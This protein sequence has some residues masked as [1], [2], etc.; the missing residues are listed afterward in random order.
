MNFKLKTKIVRAWFVHFLTCSGLIAG[1]LSITF[2]FQNDQR[3]AFMCLGLALLIDTIDGT[4]A[5]K[6]KVSKYVKNIDGKMLDSVIDFF[7]YIIIPCIMIF[8]FKIVPLP[9]EIIIPVIILVISAISYSNLN[10]IFYSFK[11]CS[12]KVYPYTTSQKIK[13]ILNCFY[14]FMV[15]YDFK[16]FTWNVLSISKYL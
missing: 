13:D 2:I 15:F 4:L 3:S 9:F 14:D 1:F 5:R 10:L 7:N 12:Y 8:W 6:F 16:D 11:I